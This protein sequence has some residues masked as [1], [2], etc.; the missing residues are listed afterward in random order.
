MPDL[1]T[2]TC[3][4]CAFRKS[5]PHDTMPHDAKRAYCPRCKQP[6]PLNH[7]TISLDGALPPLDVEAPLAGQ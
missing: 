7:D 6:F 1:I 2:I 3:P 4:H 5:I